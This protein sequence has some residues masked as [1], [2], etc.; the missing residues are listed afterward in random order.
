LNLRSGPG[1]NY[2]IVGLITRGTP[3]NEVMTKGDWMQIEP[4]PG[5][6]AFV[7]A[8][9]L[10]QEAPVV[11]AT[12]PPAEV[13]VPTTT[14]VVESQPIATEA[15]NVVETA[16]TNLAMTA[17]G[18]ETNALATAETNEAPPPPRIVTHEGF[19]RHVGSVIAPTEYEL[20]D[21]N[22][23]ATINYLYSSTTNLNLS[24]Y[25]GLHIVVT[26]EEGLA[27]R[28]HD[29]PVLTVQRIYVIQ[30]PTN[31]VRRPTSSGERTGHRP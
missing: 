20:Y 15:T 1:E 23:F 28:W 27:Q 3:V 24:R 31:A 21:T 19:V 6:Y 7:A 14:P 26:G 17:A 30:T 25:N 2:S 18:T 8:M 9:Y 5:A 12:P 29:T 10:K 16:G 11:A 22:T 4:P 13:P